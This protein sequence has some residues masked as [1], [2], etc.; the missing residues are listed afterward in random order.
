MTSG[1]M[2]FVWRAAERD[3]TTYDL[4]RPAMARLWAFWGEGKDYNPADRALGEEVMARFPQMPSLARHRLA[5]RARVVRALVG[6]YG[7]DQ[8]LVAGVDMPLVDEVHT[9]AQSINP[10]ARVVYADADELAM[11]YAEAFFSSGLTG[12]CGYV[13]AGLDD[14]RAV[15]D[16]AAE[17]LDL[18]RP[19]AVLLINSLEVLGD[20]QAAAAVS[21]FRTTLAAGSHIA[22]CHLTAE[23]DRGLAVLG[24]MCAEASP[25]SPCVRAP[26]GLGALFTGMAMIPPGLVSA[27]DWRPDPGPWPV[28]IGVDLWCGVGRIYGPRP[29]RGP[30][31]M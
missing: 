14:P 24:S 19:V 25:G 16:G 6:E 9:I 27:P 1:D 17:T 30:R 3:L 21:A 20:P 28:P 22:I 15:L 29:E 5:F 7:I 18:D 4:D 31:W 12:A 26:A 8:V 2:A 13:Q 10:H 23:H 11:L